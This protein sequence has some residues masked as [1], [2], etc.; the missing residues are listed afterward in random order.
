MKKIFI[1]NSMDMNS[2]YQ[3]MMKAESKRTSMDYHNYFTNE[4]KRIN[5]SF[6][7]KPMS[8]GMDIP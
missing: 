6:Y 3:N 5:N 7:E 2:N 4:N 8:K 1:E